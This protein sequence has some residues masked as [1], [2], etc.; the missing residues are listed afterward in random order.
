MSFVELVKGKKTS[1]R[2]YFADGVQLKKRSNN[3]CEEAFVKAIAKKAVKPVCSRIKSVKDL[4][5]FEIKVTESN[6][7][8]IG[9]QGLGWFNFLAKDQTFR[10]YVPKGVS[11]YTSRPK[12]DRK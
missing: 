12:I 2:C 6:Y 8:D 3:K 4:D 9:I 5:V 10:I 1:L 11:I 7:R